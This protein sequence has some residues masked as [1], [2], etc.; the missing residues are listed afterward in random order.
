MTT[1]IALYLFGL[2]IFVAGMILR[3][4]WQGTH[5]LLSLRNVIL[6]GYIVFMLT[7][8]A[9]DILYGPRTAFILYHP[10]ATTLI[11]AAMATVMLVVFLWSYERGF[12]VR[13]F[14]ARMPTTRTIPSV[15]GLVVIA[16]LLLASGIVMRLAI[17]P[18]PTQISNNLSVAFPAVACGIAG[19]IWGPRLFNPIVIAGVAVVVIVGTITVT[20]G[21][22][23][24]RPLVA[25][26]GALLW[27]LY[28]SYMRYERP[29]TTLLKLGAIS[30]IP[31]IFLAL[32]TSVRS[33]G[34][35]DRTGFEHV[36]A[37]QQQGNLGEGVILLAA[38]QGTAANSMWLIE[39][40]P[41][42]GGG[43]FETRP[44]F[45][46]YYF[47]VLPIPREIWEDKP[48]ALSQR[49]PTMAAVT[50]VN[51]A[52]L[53]L[54]V[55][56]I[57]HAAAEGGWIALLVYSVLGGLLIRFFDEILQRNTWS[58]F[59]VLAMGAA[60]G[61]VLGIPRGETSVMAILFVIQTIG[62]YLCLLALGKVFEAFYSPA[63]SYDPGETD[64][65]FDQADE[66]QVMA[67]SDSPDAEPVR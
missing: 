1:F 41:M 50:R 57:G 14:A 35:H 15:A 29:S 28:Y 6:V 60:L 42:F 16:V 8:G 54:S 24:R 59:V 27:G 52:R 63:L 30:I 21:A 61:Q 51:R 25:L 9:A 64:N 67:W 40:Y 65:E 7:G 37:I 26:A 10:V 13:R 12:F 58:P 43:R 38:G 36:A 2:A 55:G 49:L 18:L 22:F 4:Y 48:D 33:A 34:E 56:V 46:V 32:F 3:Q 19:W 39:Q 17:I 11:Y 23:G 62:T 45:T 47:L 20:T 66:H 53:K 5:D 31:V 44:L